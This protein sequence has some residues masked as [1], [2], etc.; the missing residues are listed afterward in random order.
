M[1]NLRNG[2]SFATI[3]YDASITRVRG[4]NEMQTITNR[5]QPQE[6]STDI[7]VITAEI[8]AYKRIAGEAIFEIGRR[9]KHVK[10]EKLA[11]GRGGWT[12]WLREVEIEESQARRFIAVV[13]ELGD[14]YRGTYHALGLRALYEIATLSSE[15]RERP[16][17]IPSTG[18]TKT[19]DEMTVRELREVK[20]ALREAETAR[21][22]AEARAE[23]AEQDYELV[24]ETLEAVE[25]QPPKVVADPTI[26]D[27]LKRYEAKYGDI[28]GE[29][30]ERISN[31]TEVDGAAA[32]FADDT[33]TY[34][35]NYAHLTTF[36]SVFTGISDE[37]YEAYRTSLDAL[38]E[39]V[40]GMRR[41]L[42]SSP[43]GKAEVI[44]ITEYRA[45]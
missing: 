16:H 36:R 12:A 4:G 28:D 30:T 17:T 3:P 42:D 2:C 15:Q 25:A 29:V 44:D 20:K 8:N 32:H 38:Q 22:E 31:H 27:R 34:L 7:H 5:E 40:N 1:R 19:V 35:L 18:E 24:R 13:E 39:F 14:E 23:K 10:E 11:E 45:N 26:S 21:K 9:L 43:Q 41:V 33:Q 37:A 6:L